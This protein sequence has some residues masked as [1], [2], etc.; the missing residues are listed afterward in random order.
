M[1][2]PVAPPTD[3][4][5]D[6]LTRELAAQGHRV[7]FTGDGGEP[8]LSFVGGRLR[9][10]VVTGG[11]AIELDLDAGLARRPFL[12]EGLAVTEGHTARIVPLYAHGEREWFSVIEA[13]LTS[14]DRPAPAPWR[15][16]LFERRDGRGELLASHESYAHTARTEVRNMYV[17]NG[18]VAVVGL[19]GSI[20]AVVGGRVLLLAGPGGDGGRFV[21]NPDPNCP[22][23]KR[24]YPLPAEVDVKRLLGH[25]PSGRSFVMADAGEIV[26]RDVATG[27][28]VVSRY[29][30][31]FYAGLVEED[32]VV[33]AHAGE[34]PHVRRWSVSAPDRRAISEG[35]IYV[36]LT[37]T[38]DG[39][40]YGVT[41]DGALDRL[42]DG[43]AAAVVRLP[44]GHRVVAAVGGDALAFVVANDATPPVHAI[45]IA[46]R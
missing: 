19:G 17:E 28:K 26:R 41:R 2:D 7:V 5:P 36:Q 8:S 24:C 35:K 33:L 43:A 1:T 44:P 25:A 23:N 31:F 13:P 38:S 14:A 4:T 27:A 18:G 12:G 45:V 30:N 46:A 20:Y 37:R 6:P 34:P 10:F 39:A 3:A 15:V 16:R 32:A 21:E 22:P 42:A 9:G 29:E 40:L 11:A